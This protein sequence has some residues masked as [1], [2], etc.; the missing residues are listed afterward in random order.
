MTKIELETDVIR[1]HSCCSYNKEQLEN[2]QK[3]G[4][5]YC[6]EIFSPKQIKDWCDNGKTAICP[7]CGIDSVIYDNEFYPVKKPFLEKMKKYW[8]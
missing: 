5:F 3:Y 1:A 6:L 4:C 8:F 2:A 7:F